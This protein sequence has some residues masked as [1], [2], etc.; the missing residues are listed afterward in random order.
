MGASTGGGRP[1]LVF[2]LTLLLTGSLDQLAKSLAKSFLSPGA[3]LRLWGFL[4]LNLTENVGSAFGLFQSGWLPITATIV[5]CV[6]VLG[7]ACG[8]GLRH[9]P[10]RSIPLG[11]IVGGALGNLLDRLRLGA[12]VDFIDLQVW[13]VFN[14]A[15]IAITVGIL[16]LALEAFRRR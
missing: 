11:L 3:P 10:T 14:L 13:P 8:G 6:V 5:V 4:H 16:I 9:A 2:S 1:L 12:V 7:Y 15:D